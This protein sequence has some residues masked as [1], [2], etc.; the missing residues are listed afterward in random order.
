MYELQALGLMMS[1]GDCVKNIGFVDLNMFF[2]ALRA[3]RAFSKTS[4]EN[5]SK[6]I[7]QAALEPQWRDA[8]NYV[9]LHFL[10]E[11]YIV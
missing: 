8:L 11:Y 6:L 5:G 7:I 4:P 2:L 10:Y 1:E 3:M 9:R